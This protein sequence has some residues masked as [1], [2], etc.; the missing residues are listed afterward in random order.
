MRLEG[1]GQGLVTLLW[2]RRLVAGHL[3]VTQ[4]RA[5]RI[6]QVPYNAPGL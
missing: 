4:E 6:R 5:V 3:P 1:F 2:G